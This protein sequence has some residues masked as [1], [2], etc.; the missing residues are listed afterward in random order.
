[1]NAAISTRPNT[2]SESGAAVELD[3]P[4]EDEHRFDVEHHEE[5]RVHVVADVRL[6]EAE[7]RVGAGLVGHELVRVG[8]RGRRSR[9]TPSMAPT[10]S[11][12][13]PMNT[14]TAR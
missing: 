5:Q 8:V 7:H 14:A 1:M 4:R 12:A 9:P 13:A 10:I 3:R 6:A 2:P 11:R